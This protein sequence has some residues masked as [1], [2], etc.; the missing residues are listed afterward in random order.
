ME[1]PLL[2]W[3]APQLF[4]RTILQPLLI[5]VAQMFDELRERETL[6]RDSKRLLAIT[7]AVALSR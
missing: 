5:G 4:Q 2:S 7:V 3:L 6:V 1:T